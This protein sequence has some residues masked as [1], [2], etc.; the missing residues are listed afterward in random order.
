VYGNVG[1]IERPQAAGTGLQSVPKRTME[2]G[3]H[4]LR[5]RIEVDI[6]LKRH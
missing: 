6:A 5:F 1:A 2:Q 3:P 4:V